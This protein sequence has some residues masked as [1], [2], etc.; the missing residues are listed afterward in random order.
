[1]IAVSSPLAWTCF[2][3]SARCFGDRCADCVE[4]DRQVAHHLLVRA[5]VRLEDLG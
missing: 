3:A 5:Q 4:V 2:Q 1:L